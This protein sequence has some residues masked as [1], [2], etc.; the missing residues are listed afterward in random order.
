[1]PS[2]FLLENELEAIKTRTGLKTQTFSLHYKSGSP[3]ALSAAVEQLCSKVEAAVRD[4][5]EVLVLSDRIEDNK[6]D[7]NCPPIP[8][9]LA[10]GAV[11]HQLIRQA[12]LMCLP[13]SCLS[14]YLC[15]HTWAGQGGEICRL[16]CHVLFSEL[17]CTVLIL[18][19]HSGRGFGQ[20]HPLW[21]R[22]PN[23]A[24]HIRWRF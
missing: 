13:H 21:L 12:L 1:M 24:A 23:A 10:A 2:P 3:G 11:H 4:G 16:L 20:R 19:P 17:I 8:T 9:L 22:Q 14:V 6:L 5:V 18:T 7:G 15:K